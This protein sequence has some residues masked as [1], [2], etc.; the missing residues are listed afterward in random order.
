MT[1]SLLVS[2]HL[3]N[4]SKI[5]SLFQKVFK[6][7]VLTVLLLFPGYRLAAQISPL[8]INGTYTVAAETTLEV[9]D[10]TLQSGAVLYV[11][12]TLIV[13][14]DLTMVN[15]APQLITGPEARIIVDG[16][17]IIANKVNINL[18]CY[19]IVTGNFTISGGGNTDINIDDASIYVFGTFDAGS[20]SL[21]IC[22][23]YDNNTENYDPEI[24]HVGN[25]TAYEDNVDD[26]IIPPE[27]I[28]IID[29]CSLKPTAKISGDAVICD[30]GST[31]TISVNLSG[32]APWEITTQRNGGESITV[33]NINMNPYVFYVSQAG[34]YTVS[35]VSDANCTGT[36]SGSAT[37]TL[38]QF[39]M[40]VSD[41]TAV[42]SGEHCPEFLGPFN[43]SNGAYNP[44]VT[45]V[46]FKA[47]KESSATGSWTFDFE[48]DETGDVEVYELAVS[49]NT[50]A[51]NYTGDDA[52][53]TL[54]AGDNTEVT[55]IFQVI[56]VPGTSLDV[57]FTISGGN[58]GTCSETGTS[59]DNTINH[60]INAMP[61][62]GNIE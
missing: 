20:T 3:N 55:F 23:D 32:T 60:M 36:A 9:L 33:T 38:H 43:A 17:A 59:A 51:I 49:G 8:Q 6:V 16:N 26:E 14:G 13:H 24:C 45:E 35:A 29:P 27:I 30:D 22:A 12:G 19:F 50:S 37:V 10:L 40:M 47:V 39:N 25:Q 34:V 54:N 31:A 4:L 52:G 57:G 41:Q 58:D 53:G 56:N 61:A 1:A 5:Q 21:E 62:I 2:N 48:I 28:E 7:S 46:V 18:S 44:G 42:A 11:Y 15:N